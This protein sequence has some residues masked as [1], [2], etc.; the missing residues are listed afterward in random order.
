M[1]I[2]HRAPS[3]L[4]L[5]LL[6]TACASAPSLQPALPGPPARTDTPRLEAPAAEEPPDNDTVFIGRKGLRPAGEEALRWL[7]A[8]HLHGLDFA[9]QPLEVPT[10]PV[11]DGTRRAFEA[12]LTAKLEHLV[13]A[14]PAAP[15]EMHILEDAT[16]QFYISPDTTWLTAPPGAA[17]PTR[18]AA[19]RAA[20]AKG[21]A[22]LREALEALLPPHPQ[23]RRL[24]DAAAR[25][26][27]LCRAGGWP[28]TT[29]PKLPKKRLKSWS[30]PS[31]FTVTLQRRLAIEGYYRGEPSGVWDD[32]TA[33]ALTDFRADRQVPQKGLDED[34][35]Y[36]AMNVPCEA[37]LATIV[38]NIKRW[39]VSAWKS[40]PTFVEVNIA[41]QELRFVRDHTPV[42]SQRTIV[43][44]PKW[45]FDK[46]LERRI[47]LH[48]TPV[49]TDH[50]SRIVLNPTWA[51]PPRI[52]KKEI[53]V[54]V[55]KDPT[56]LEK[57]K[58]TLVES[59]RGR[60]YIQAPGR[61]NALGVIKILFPNSESVYL[62]DTPKKGPFKL[63]VRA[64]S[65][66]CVRVQN[67]VDFGVALLA[68]DAAQSKQPFDEAKIRKRAGRGGTVNI[69]LAEEI[70]VF[71]EYYTASVSDDGRVRFH[72][73]IYAYDAEV[74]GRRR[75]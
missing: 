55:A 53:D 59:P 4:A 24:V 8:A 40:E 38:L 42:M 27:S 26:E 74:L 49:L 33:S 69:D 28:Q 58:I 6:A 61:D 2:P 67:A 20:A 39:R 5:C 70:P 30:P 29:K 68:H 63:A 1:S 65:H 36:E 16:Q 12:A 46:D 19:I 23:Y 3:A 21:D 31:E 34:A 9:R 45:Y 73:D 48:S 64:L 71:L 17:D 47:N 72:P 7:A 60:T 13:A 22:A 66:G 43:G 41:A 25:Y 50:I 32:Q 44:A 51:V 75:R 54:E 56:Y 37:R 10:P 15:R 62:H 52:A 35:L 11:S 14:L 18:T 57:N